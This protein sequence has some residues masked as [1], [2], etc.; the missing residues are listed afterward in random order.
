[1]WDRENNPKVGSGLRPGSAFRYRQLNA[2]LNISLNTSLTRKAGPQGFAK[3]VLLGLIALVIGA[4]FFFGDSLQ[5]YLSFAALQSG[6]ESLQG[7]VADNP[8]MATLSYFVVYV[9]VTAMSLPGAAILTLAGGAMFG[10]VWGFIVVSFASTIG[11]TVAMLIARVL[12]GD[13]VQQR[14]AAQL[15][16]VNA[17]LEKDGGFYLFGLRMVPLLPFFVIN[18]V[19]GLTK[20]P[21]LKFYWISQLGMAA[22]TMVFVFAGT[23]LAE[24]ASPKDVLSPGLIAA[25]TLLGLFPIIAK[26]GMDYFQRGR[27]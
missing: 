21:A 3:L 26:K 20:I 25:L 13:W 11:A 23:Q 14:Y 2:P 18:L 12:A 6:R 1:M 16:S 17:G 8:V 10:F 7:W 22:G 5:Q 27:A 19:M 4:Y 15:A 9:L 24:V